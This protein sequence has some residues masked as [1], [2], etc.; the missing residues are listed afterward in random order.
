MKPSARRQ[1]LCASICAAHFS[2]PYIIVHSS[3]GL[4]VS[5]HAQQ[6]RF[7]FV[8]PLA[9]GHDAASGGHAAAAGCERRRAA[10]GE[11]QWEFFAR[12]LEVGWV[13]DCPSANEG[14]SAAGVAWQRLHLCLRHCGSP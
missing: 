4:R 9:G 8:S 13:V 14:G 12:R 10:R 1:A 7:G 11:T 3:R 6:M 5:G 2:S